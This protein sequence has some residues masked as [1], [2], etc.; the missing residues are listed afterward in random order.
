MTSS[1]TRSSRSCNK[2]IPTTDHIISKTKLK[3]KK[4]RMSKKD[5]DLE[6]RSKQEQYVDYIIEF[7]IYMF[8]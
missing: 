2:K 8:I 6:N 7:V 3:K 1:I 4:Q 5:A